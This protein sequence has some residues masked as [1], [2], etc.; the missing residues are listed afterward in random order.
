MV[1]KEILVVIVVAVIAIIGLIV[2]SQLNSMCI[3]IC[4]QNLDPS[5]HS[6]CIE[7]CNQTYSGVSNT[8]EQFFP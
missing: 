3:H 5:T 6:S 2:L 7:R 4:F 8:I 1:D